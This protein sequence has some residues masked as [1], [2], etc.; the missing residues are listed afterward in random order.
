MNFL[1]YFNNKF[2]NIIPLKAILSII[3]ILYCFSLYPTESKAQPWMVYY[4]DI[5]VNYFLNDGHFVWTGG[6]SGLQRL[7]K[8]THELINYNRANSVLPH[9]FISAIEKDSSGNIWIGT[10]GGLCK[11]DGT[12]LIFLPFPNGLI[13]NNSI[14]CLACSADGKIWCGTDYGLAVYNGFTWMVYNT[15]DSEIPTN[16]VRGLL[17]QKPNNIWICGYSAGL[18]KFDQLNFT[19]YKD[20]YNGLPPNGFT[21]IAINNK[22]TV[23]F[24]W[25]MGNFRILDDIKGFDWKNING[26]SFTEEISNFFVDKNNSLWVCGYR[27]IGKYENGNW[28]E[29]DF[30]PIVSKESIDAIQVDDNQNIWFSADTGMTK[31]DGKNTVHYNLSN[32]G[33][34]DNYIKQIAIDRENNKWFNTRNGL[35]KFDGFNWTYFDMA[36]FNNHFKNISNIIFDKNNV[37]WFG[38]DTGL[39]SYDGTNYRVFNTSNSNLQSNVITSLLLDSSNILWI[40]TKSGLSKISGLEIS[41]F[42]PADYGA[43]I[44]HLF[45]SDLTCDHSGNVWFYSSKYSVDISDSVIITQFNGVN[46]KNLMIV[47]SLTNGLNVNCLGVDSKNHVWIGLITYS[48]TIQILYEFDGTKFNKYSY[49]VYSGDYDHYIDGQLRSLIIDKD[50]N[51]WL[52]LSGGVGSGVFVKF[53]FGWELHDAYNSPEPGRGVYCLNIDSYDNI[54]LGTDLGVGVFNSMGVVDVEDKTV[55]TNINNLEISLSPNPAQSHI[56]ITLPNS[57]LTNPAITIYNSMGSEIRRFGSEDY[58]VAAR[59]I[60]DRVSDPRGLLLCV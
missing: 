45:V 27:K 42:N 9:N 44:N 47:D 25:D 16:E 59:S 38:S 51:K 21:R 49:Q 36:N 6:L 20:K 14:Y 1:N 24:F 48:D 18:I 30:T 3:F 31:F 22:D 40:G 37:M 54:W 55:P 2:F 17:F 12:N 60:F 34:P 32:S 28:S 35:T 23:L 7:N 58:W 10:W 39:V 8:N 33:L 11:F 56:S 29:Y 13:K 43:D 52:G 41:A 46:H 19:I 4:S 5:Q 26:N 53:K 50:D 15:F 57:G